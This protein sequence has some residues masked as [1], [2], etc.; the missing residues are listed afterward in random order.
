MNNSGQLYDKIEDFYG[1]R[2][3][4][5]PLNDRI[6]LMKFKPWLNPSRPAAMHEIAEKLVEKAENENYSKIFV[7]I[8]RRAAAPFL[9]EKYRKEA[10]IPR[11]YQGREDAVFLGRYLSE[12]RMKKKDAA[13]LDKILELSRDK[14]LADDADLRLQPLDDKFHLR[15]CTE[16]D[17]ARMAAVYRRVFMSYPFPI[18]EPDYLRKTMR[19]HVDYFCVE[20]DGKIIALASA[21]KDQ[22][23]LNAEM[24]DFATLPEWRGHRLAKYLLT[25]M[26]QH[27]AKKDGIK[28]A[29]T[30]ARAA[31]PGMNV[32]FAGIAYNYGGCL[33]NNTNIS[34]GLESMNVWYKSIA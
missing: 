17:A 24:T 9:A 23:N 11:F 10:Q 2:I 22:E 21:E 30:I 20:A 4:H 32:T 16:N 1:T 12:E 5:G 31:S 8:P 28:T 19:S 25:R 26:E 18:H 13:K 27:I 33:V 14:Q 34:G 6:Y 7:K 3:Q 29:F 15:K